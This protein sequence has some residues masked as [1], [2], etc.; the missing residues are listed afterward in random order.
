MEDYELINRLGGGSFADVYKAREKSTG[1]IVAIKILKKKYKKWEECLELR[2]VKSL[3]KLQDDSLSNQKGVDNIIKLKQIIFI[4]KTGTL[5]LVF[6]YMEKDLFALMKSREP[7]TLSEYEIK[8]L[9]YQTLLGLAHMHKY[10]FFHRDMKPENLLITNNKLKIADFGLAREIRSLPPY[11]EYVST[12]YYRAPECILKST[13]YNSPIDI[14]ALGCIMAE[15]YLHPQP[16]FYGANEKEVLFR[17]CSVLGTPTHDTWFEGVTQAQLIGIKFPNNSGIELK[18]IIKNASDDAI[19]L[20]KQMIKWDPNKRETAQSLLKHK[21]FDGFICSQSNLN[22]NFSKNFDFF[23]NDNFKK[24]S[25]ISKVNNKNNNDKKNELKVSEIKDEE[26]EFTKMLD[27]TEGFNKLI[28]MLKKEKNE[29][30]DNYE[31]EKSKINDYENNDLK[32]LLLSNDCNDF[33]KESIA[34]K[35]EQKRKEKEFDAYF[36][37]NED[38]IR[39]TITN[40]NNSFKNT[41]FNIDLF[42]NS[43]KNIDTNFEENNISPEKN[44][45]GPKNIKL[46]PIHLIPTDNNANKNFPTNYYNNKNYPNNINN[47]NLNINPIYQNDKSIKPNRKCILGKSISCANMGDFSH[48]TAPNAKSNIKNNYDIEKNKDGFETKVRLKPI[49]LSNRRGSAKKF[50][51]VTKE[52]FNGSGSGG[53]TAT[54]GNSLSENNNN[55]F[56]KNLFGYNYKNGCPI[57]MKNTF[58]RGGIN[59]LLEGLQQDNNGYK[60]GGFKGNATGVYNKNYNKKEFP[61][62]IINKYQMKRNDSIFGE[63]SRRNR[64]FNFGLAYNNSSSDFK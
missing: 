50:L 34:D 30:D 37:D 38:S 62:P 51:E 13:N 64:P 23:D 7:K 10:G 40:I 52:K 14:W 45:F 63:G 4:N 61:P 8:D 35:K 28:S 21:F 5:N 9:I 41:T 18:N 17:I 27:D 2:E 19:D 59:K 46:K 60:I 3:Q 32:N 15:M 33:F 22:L 44:I 1:E 42:N 54:D 20:I 11:T 43:N 29:E 58:N 49:N 24:F 31:K 12:R 26:N 16:L 36:N 39:K 56:N 47:N 6:E 53:S 25:N 55:D 48:Q 57:I